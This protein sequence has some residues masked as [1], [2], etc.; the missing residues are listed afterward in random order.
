VPY[1]SNGVLRKLKLSQFFDARNPNLSHLTFKVII[2]PPLGS[3]PRKTA[4][5]LDLHDWT[6]L[7]RLHLRDGKSQRWISKEFG[8]SR[9]TVARYLKNP[10]PP[11]YTMKQSRTQPLREQWR[12][13][14]DEM[15][16]EDVNAPR[17]QRHTA[18]RVYD[19]LVQEHGY[20]ASL[21]TVQHMVT[22]WHRKVPRQVMVPLSFEPGKDAQVDFSESIAELDGQ[23]QKV[24]SVRWLAT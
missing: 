5:L 22:E 4:S 10:D 15:L 16:S 23:R 21:R 14:V 11:K 13:I 19:R 18:R 6:V 3:S 7:R 24:V 1:T 17:K 12:P 2:E 8:I 20:S 9:N